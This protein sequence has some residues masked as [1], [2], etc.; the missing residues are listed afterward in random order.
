MSQINI[1]LARHGE[2][3]FN[4]KNYI[5]GQ[6]D[7]PL[8]VNGIEGAVNLGKKLSHID[9]DYVVS[10]NLNRA[11]VTLDILLEE[12]K[13]N[14]YKRFV[15][16]DFG[17]INFG[18]YEGDSGIN[19]WENKSKEYGIDINEVGRN[20]LFDKYEYLYHHE[21]NPIAERMDNFKLRLKRSMNNIVKEAQTNGYKD[22]LVVS[23]GI[24]LHGILTLLVDDYI[25]DG[26]SQNSSV[27]KFVYNDGKFT[28][29]YIGQRE[30]EF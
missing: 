3:I 6:C 24:T 8:T 13:F 7:A 28:C 12:N 20:N 1:Y 2:T 15:D 22:V 19:F 14:N 18:E 10:S 29:K 30:G 26:F 4:K 25:F 17:E 11:I 5:Q 21:R 27:T 16:A 23:H 9:F